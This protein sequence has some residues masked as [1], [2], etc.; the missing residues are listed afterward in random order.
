MEDAW[1]EKK[2]WITMEE[3]MNKRRAKTRSEKTDDQKWKTFQKWQFSPF[4]RACS[5]CERETV[6]D[7]PRSTVPSLDVNELFPALS[8]A[9]GGC[10][11]ATMPHSTIGDWVLLGWP[12]L[13]GETASGCLWGKVSGW[14]SVGGWSNDCVK[15]GEGGSGTSAS[16]ASGP[17]TTAGSRG[18]VL[19]WWLVLE[20]GLFFR[21]TQKK[22]KKRTIIVT[23][24]CLTDELEKGEGA[25]AR[26][27]SNA[28]QPPV[29]PE[30]TTKSIDNLNTYI[31][32][33]HHLSKSFQKRLVLTSKDGSSCC[34]PRTLWEDVTAQRSLAWCVMLSSSSLS[35]MY[36]LRRGA[37]LGLCAGLGLGLRRG[38][39]LPG[40]CEGDWRPALTI[41]NN[42]SLRG[43]KER[44]KNSVNVW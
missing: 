13:V 3:S 10:R 5:A 35:S 39:E 43:R 16:S 25:R 31:F 17:Q 29:G 28:Y 32:T 44:Q 40:N 33:H 30:N 23:C 38:V 14:T 11:S 20:P 19:P 9:G 7:D 2:V 36:T 21:S 18:D 12:W 1:R 6:W 42:R 22:K 8:W 37:L 41:V 4:F 15:R 34:F 24:V 26:Q 27:N